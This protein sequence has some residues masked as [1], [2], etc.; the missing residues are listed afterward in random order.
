MEDT[1][2]ICLPWLPELAQYSVRDGSRIDWA[3]RNP[4]IIV[5]ILTNPWNNLEKSRD[6][7]RIDGAVKRERKGDADNCG[8]DIQMVRTTQILQSPPDM[9]ELVEHWG[10]PSLCSLSPGS[11][12]I[13]KEMSGE[14]IC[15]SFRQLFLFPYIRKFYAHISLRVSMHVLIFRSSFLSSLPCWQC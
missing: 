15:F 6:G 7:S 5:L 12:S 11:Q 9:M 13:C 14:T 3:F 4:R 1:G 10:A 8:A 2:T